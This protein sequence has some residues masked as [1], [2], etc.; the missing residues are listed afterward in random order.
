MSLFKANYDYLLKILLLLR[1]AK[2]TYKKAKERIN[3]LIDLHQNLQ[4]TAKIV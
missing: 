2:K 1:Q 3:K 4:E